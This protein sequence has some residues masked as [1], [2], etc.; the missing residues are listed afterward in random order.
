M[1]NQETYD[2]AL[3]LAQLVLVRLLPAYLASTPLPN[4]QLRLLSSEPP[5]LVAGL[6]TPLPASLTGD[7]RVIDRDAVLEGGIEALDALQAKLGSSW[8]LGA[9]LVNV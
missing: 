8:A 1:P 5:A 6:A 7:D 4:K 9:E 2:S 3:A